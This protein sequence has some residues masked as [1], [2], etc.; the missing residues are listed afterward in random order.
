MALARTSASAD[1]APGDAK[2]GGGGSGKHERR[3]T[4]ERHPGSTGEATITGAGSQWT[5]S[6]APLRR[7]VRQWDAN[8]GGGGTGQ[9]LRRIPR[10]LVGLDR[11]GDDHR[12]RLPVDQ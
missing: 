3:A 12:H 11:R 6:Y 7:H 9:Q 4:S 8:G 1:P 2:S 10:L 5:N